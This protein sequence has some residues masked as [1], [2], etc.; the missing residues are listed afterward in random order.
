M[1]NNNRAT[2]HFAGQ[3]YRLDHGDDAAKVMHSKFP[4]PSSVSNNHNNASDLPNSLSFSDWSLYQ[5]LIQQPDCINVEL[6]EIH[7]EHSS[8]FL[9][10]LQ[11]TYKS[12][13]SNGTHL[14]TKAPKHSFQRFRYRQYAHDNQ[15]ST[16]CLGEKEC[17]LNMSLRTVDKITDRITFLTNQRTVSFGSPAISGY[18]TTPLL[19]P[20]PITNCNNNNSN[21]NNQQTMSFRKIVALAGLTQEMAEQVGC[22]S[23]SQHYQH[24]KPFIVMRALV[25]QNRAL[26]IEAL[27]NVNDTN[28]NV[29]TCLMRDTN[30]DIFKYIVSFLVP[31][32]NL[33]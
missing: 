27:S 32:T 12:T 24:V 3:H 29:L 20:Y 5:E 18:T 23:E 6:S 19:V 2:L 7:V 31:E 11:A 33:H 8:W 30:Q 14:M 15:H 22:F 16:L 17:L 13:F 26:P 10:S 1:R 4:P 9:T 28:S 21:N 25:E